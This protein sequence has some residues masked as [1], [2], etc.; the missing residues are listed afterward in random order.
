M[1]RWDVCRVGSPHKKPTGILTNAPWIQDLPCDMETRPHVHV[2]LVGL[3]EDY[4][5]S[6]VREKVWYTFL[7]AEYPEGMC[8]KL[9][10]DFQTHLT[11]EGVSRHHPQPGDGG[12]ADDGLMSSLSRQEKVANVRALKLERKKKEES[13]KER[14]AKE[15]AACAGG[16][17]QPSHGHCVAPPP[18]KKSTFLEKK[19]TLE[20]LWICISQKRPCDFWS[21]FEVLCLCW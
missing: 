14:F 11:A 19:S 7:A 4:R 16:M 18:E 9:A 21:Y 17:R 20:I 5:P 10:K 8:N 1:V 3:V 6:A 2:P 15:D 12:G 13:K